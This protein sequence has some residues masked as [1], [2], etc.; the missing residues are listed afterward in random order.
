MIKINYHGLCPVCGDVLSI[1]EIEAFKCFRKSKNLKTTDSEKLKEF[2]EFFKKLNNSPL[3][4]I[5]RIWAKR[6]LEG[7]SESLLAPT[8]IGKT[9]FGITISIYF[10][11][12]E[13][14]ICYLLFPTTTIIKNLKEK[15]EDFR[16]KTEKFPEIIFYYGELKSK[17]K[18]IVKEKIK[19]G[20]FDILIT[21][22][23]FLTKDFEIL[24][25][26]KFDFIFVDDVDSLLKN[27]R[28]LDKILKVFKENGILLFTS[29]TGRPGRGAKILKEKTGLETGA[30]RETLRKI[31]DFYV[32]KKE[33]DYLL[34]ILEKLGKGGLLFTNSEN[35]AQEIYEKI[36][37]K[38]PSKI[39]IS[40]EKK[41]FDDFIEGK[42][43][44]L[45]GVA[46]PY[47][48]LVRGIDLPKVIRYAIFWGAPSF[49]FNLKKE[50]LPEG[51]INVLARKIYALKGDKN[52]LKLLRS[53]KF[54]ILEQKI[55]EFIEKSDEKILL[56]IGISKEEETLW[57]PDIKTYIQASGRTSRLFSGGLS[58]GLSIIFEEE[59]YLNIFKEKAI[60]WDIEIK[61]FD[62]KAL[63]KVIEIIDRDR[64]EME[65]PRAEF[66]PVTPLLFVVESPNKA[67]QIA[68]F[69]GKPIPK[70]I[71]EV[72]GYEVFTGEHLLL[73]VASIGHM[74]DLTTREIGFHGIERKNGDFVLHYAPIKRCRNCG[75]QF[76]DITNECPKCK[77]NNLYNAGERIKAI[78]KM[79]E[80][81]EEVLIGTDPDTEGEK[82]AWDIYNFLKPYAREIKRAEF[83][84]VTKNAILKAIKE[85]REFDINLVNAQI[86][87]RTEDRLTGFELSERVQ[88]VFKNSTLSAGRAQ[89]PLLGWVVERE[90]ELKRKIPFFINEEL[91][92][93]WKLKVNFRLRRGKNR[94]KF[95]IQKIG[96]EEKERV[97][98][99][100]RTDTMLKEA[101][102]ILKMSTN[103]IMK[104]AQK[105]F[106]LGLITYHRTDSTRISDK[107]LMI[108]RYILKENFRGRS[109][110]GK[111]AHEG[112]RPTK[113]LKPEELRENFENIELAEPLDS[114]DISL[115]RLI[116]NRFLASQTLP[117]KKKIAKYKIKF[118]N[119]EFEEER[120]IDAQGLTKDF[121]P[122]AF[123]IVPE[124]P[125]GEVYLE[126][127][128][129]YFSEVFPYTQADLVSLMKERGIG[130][131]S[132]YATL[133]DRLFQ[134]KYVEEKNN[135]V[136]ATELGEKVFYFLNKNY[137]E[138]ISE[139]RTRLLEK[140]MEEIEENKITPEEV[141]KTIWEEV[142]KI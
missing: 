28:N 3:R 62:E 51:I 20:N 93:R 55:K 138:F 100:F 31:E 13:N 75:Y 92:I 26:K 77:S 115:Y 33:F 76:A 45:I 101:Q 72:T 17:E 131:P 43:H 124:L 25:D 136:R 49:K 82:I 104:R 80:I 125:E 111:G 56:E 84:E 137:H 34:K 127:K 118:Y 95:I 8:G 74:V 60:I 47:G 39:F 132:T 89:S 81:M 120:L 63:D 58:Q 108:A 96:E 133:I 42:T 122:Y 53:K 66:D 110:E 10:S 94:L 21:T 19:E 128:V 97:L 78:R 135:F 106:E 86:V 61:E 15:I 7:N 130:R 27:S 14:K 35:E 98:P 126:G 9:V 119:Y 134:R 90:K 116:Y 85:K 87:R 139:E 59:N 30:L 113:P 18:K 65:K 99:P 40:G 36:K 37:D 1:D 117:C 29:A 46:K 52:L 91:K 22:Y 44:V 32:E 112:I 41:E 114:K 121:Y 2:E 70:R 4:K 107:G 6:I 67:R 64:K 88:R 38:I 16:K 73:I 142:E 57:I 23:A 48:L 103:E 129:Y 102:R 11:I 5:Q 69:F 68:K 71:G 50:K 24:K 105:L 123:Y 54:N 79:A 141:L 12:K 109:F 140:R 83:H